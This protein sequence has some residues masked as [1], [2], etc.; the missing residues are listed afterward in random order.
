MQVFEIDPLC[1]WRCALIDL[2]HA[3]C[4]PEPY[5]LST[6]PDDSGDGSCY[7]SQMAPGI[8]PGPAALP[9]TSVRFQIE[10]LRSKVRDNL[11][12]PVAPSRCT[13]RGITV[14]TTRGL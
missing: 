12:H 7:R 11:V 1:A 3:D 10:G 13:G 5:A 8:G 6:V 14:G 2:A 4:L 9:W